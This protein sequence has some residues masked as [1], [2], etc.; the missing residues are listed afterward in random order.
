MPQA[1]REAFE[2]SPAAK[3]EPPNINLRVPVKES[4]KQKLPSPM[5][6]RMLLPS[7]VNLSAEGGR[8]DI[9]ITS[10]RW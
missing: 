8:A 4:S 6:R 7:A 5:A 9:H 1:E 3:S 2:N 10:A